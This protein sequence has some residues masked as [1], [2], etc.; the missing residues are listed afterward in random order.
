MSIE[1]EIEKIIV[2]GEQRIKILELKGLNIEDLPKR[3]KEGE[4]V[5]IARSKH[6]LFYSSNRE[7][8][9]K[10]NTRNWH[11]TYLEVGG[12]ITRQFFEECLRNIRRCGEILVKVN[13]KLEEENKNW[14]GNE[15]FI[16]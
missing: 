15:L 1:I 12:V 11:G 3:Y 2:R 7:R 10:G 8:T 16:I 9:V 14:K 6:Y 13:K 5:S 4:Y